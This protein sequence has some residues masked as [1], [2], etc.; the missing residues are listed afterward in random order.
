[1]YYIPVLFSFRLFNGPEN[2]L[3]CNLYGDYSLLYYMNAIFFIFL[4]GTM[5]ILNFL[6]IYTLFSSRNRVNSNFFTSKQSGIFKRD[7]KLALTS[8]CLNLFYFFLFL[9]FT[10]IVEFFPSVNDTIYTAC[11]YTCV[12]FSAFNFYILLISNSLFRKRF[13][14]IF[15]KQSPRE[16]RNRIQRVRTQSKQIKT[17]MKELISI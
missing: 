3:V 1:M 6:L 8:I 17:T 7:L 13:F 15:V 16:N 11:L 14:L 5:F 4:F 9:P 2:K 10:L 12:S